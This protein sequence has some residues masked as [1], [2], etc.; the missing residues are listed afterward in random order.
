MAVVWSVSTIHSIVDYDDV[1]GFVKGGVGAC[2]EEDLIRELF[3]AWAQ[4]LHL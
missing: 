4:G 2:A 1:A 3:G